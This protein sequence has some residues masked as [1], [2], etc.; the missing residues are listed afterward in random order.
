MRRPLFLMRGWNFE[1]I[2]ASGRQVV[3]A[4]AF[5]GSM[6]KPSGFERQ[7]KLRQNQM[8]PFTWLARRDWNA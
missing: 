4:S 6:I 5:I 3:A 7:K 2:T 1:N 8:G